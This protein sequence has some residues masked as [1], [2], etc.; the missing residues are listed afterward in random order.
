MEHSMGHVLRGL[1]FLDDTLDHTE[2]HNAPMKTAL[3]RGGVFVHDRW[4]A[5]S[6]LVSTDATFHAQSMSSTDGKINY[7]TWEEQLV[8]FLLL[9]IISMQCLFI[10][11]ATVYLPVLITITF[12]LNLLKLRSSLLANPPYLSPRKPGMSTQ[13]CPMQEICSSHNKVINI[14]FYITVQH[15]GLS[16]I[17]DI[18]ISV[19]RP[20]RPN[21]T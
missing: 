18:A 14:V 19:I 12:Y 21:V 4:S 11:N 3:M 6:V 1:W 8:A 17:L 20:T 16:M 5:F 10:S 15:Y 2:V 13:S 7:L 9:Y